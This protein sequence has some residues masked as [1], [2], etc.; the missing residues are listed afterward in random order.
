MLSIDDRL[1]SILD[2]DVDAHTDV[3]NAAEDI[4]SEIEETRQKLEALEKDLKGVSGIVAGKLAIAVRQRQPGLTV[5]LTKDG[6][7]VVS[8]HSKSLVF[9]PNLVN[10][11][12]DVKSVTPQFAGKY[13]KMFPAG[14]KTSDGIGTLADNIS[15][16]FTK[17]SR[18]LGEDITTGNGSLVF[19]GMML[20]LGK[21]SELIAKRSLTLV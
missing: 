3:L 18:S 20:T 16:F 15:Q 4:I 19:E 1:D 6:S 9:T 7:C 2:N 21:A 13:T 17:F 8:C 10:H 5:H 11:T 12:W 14:L